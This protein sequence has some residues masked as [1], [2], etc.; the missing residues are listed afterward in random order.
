MEKIVN[1]AAENALPIPI[2]SQITLLEIRS[3]VHILVLT[4]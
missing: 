2:N 4:R 1:V 3:A